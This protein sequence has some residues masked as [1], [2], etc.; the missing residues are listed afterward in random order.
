VQGMNF[1]TQK[2]ISKPYL[3]CPIR[4]TAST[5]RSAISWE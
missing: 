2:Q 5:S 4:A 3:F 1:S